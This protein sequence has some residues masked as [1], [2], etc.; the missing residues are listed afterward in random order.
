M[1]AADVGNPEDE[2]SS[3]VSS[4]SDVAPL[5]MCNCAEDLTVLSYGC[6]I[7]QGPHGNILIRNGG[8]K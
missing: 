4:R 7:R 1:T 3:W 5:W 8:V 6:G 2:M